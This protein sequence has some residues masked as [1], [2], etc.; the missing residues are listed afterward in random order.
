MEK[1][2]AEKNFLSAGG[3]GLHTFVAA[4]GRSTARIF[5]AN[6]SIFAYGPIA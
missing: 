6:S 2:Y 5:F 1:L 3:A 4:S